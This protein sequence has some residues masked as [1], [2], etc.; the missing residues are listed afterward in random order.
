MNRL[1]SVQCLRFAAAAAVVL[2]HCAS[3][4]FLFGGFGVDIF[5]VISGYIITKVMGRREA[6]AFIMDRFSRIYPIYWLCLLPLV[7]VG[8]DGDPYRLLTSITLWPVWGEWQRNYLAVGWTLHFEMLFYAAAALVLWRRALLPLLLALYGA[9][10]AIGLSTGQPVLGFVGSPMVLDFRMGVAIAMMPATQLRWRGG[11]AVAVGLIAAVWGTSS[12]F[13][14]I[15]N[16]FNGVAAWRWAAWGI[17][18]ALIVWGTM[19]FEAL[20]KGRLF[21]FG[22]AGGDASYA[23]YLSHPV[24]LLMAPTNPYL[25]LALGPPV[26]V[27]LG[28]AVHYGVEKPLLD[29]VRRLLSRDRRPSQIAQANIATSADP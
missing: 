6:G 1:V 4:K 28:F 13:G 12:D 3:G 14:A 5:F 7:V 9:T 17:P 18:A 15:E 29:K 23:L 24:F 19:Q 21:E 20:M 2:T 22:A 8:W 25:L 10:M 16:M 11:S 27:A 26:L